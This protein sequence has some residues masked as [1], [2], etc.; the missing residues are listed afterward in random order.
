MT[1]T[2]CYSIILLLVIIGVLIISSPASAQLPILHNP[3][4][5]IILLKLI[6]QGLT[7]QLVLGLMMMER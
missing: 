2:I 7:V 1:S 6:I 5:Q 3:Q 4:L